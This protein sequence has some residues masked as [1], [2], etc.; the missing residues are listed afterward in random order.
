MKRV[1]IYFCF[2]NRLFILQPKRPSDLPL[3]TPS[4]K[5]KHMQLFE[6]KFPIKGPSVYLEH[7]LFIYIWKKRLLFNV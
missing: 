6:E 3:L 4:G 5:V 7:I 1:H 2:D